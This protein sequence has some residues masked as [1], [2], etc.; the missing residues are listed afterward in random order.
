M[1]LKNKYLYH[2]PGGGNGKQKVV[3]SGGAIGRYHFN[4]L[5]WNGN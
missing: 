4:P 5:V 2:L 1:S 3:R